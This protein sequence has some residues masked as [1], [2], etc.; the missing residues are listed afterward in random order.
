MKVGQEAESPRDEIAELRAALAREERIASALREVGNALGTTLDLDDLLELI[1]G[2]LTDLLEADRCTLYL[3]DQAK[4]ELV[5]RI[6]IGEQV[7]SIRV[8]VG[9]GIAGTV[10]KTGKAI[11]LRDAYTDPR[12]EP[13]WD[14]FTGY[15]TRSMLAAPLK[16]HMGRTIGVIQVL[17][18]TVG[19][20]FTAEDEAILSALS[21]QAAVAIDNSRLFLS[22]IQK[23]HQLLS[24]K[25]KLERRV[26]DLQLLNELE[27]AMARA[28]SLEDLTRAALSALAKACQAQGA[29]LLLGEEDTGDLFQYVYDAERP[30][31]LDRFGIKAGEGL[32][33][34]AM[35]SGETIELEDASLGPH[36]HARVEGRFPF[37]IQSCL[38]MPLS[39]E[40]VFGALGL[41]SKRGG[42]PFEEEDRSLMG[43][44]GA[45]LSTAVRLFRASVQRERG[46][47]LT[48]IGRL[49]SQV[50]H[51]FKT[52]MTVI[53]GHV[54][55]MTSAD[56]P[57]VRAEHAAGVLKQLQMLTAMQ[58]EVLDFARGERRI[59]VR[60]VYL[61]RFFDDI[62]KQVEQ[63]AEGQP[64][65]VVFDV[66]TMVTARFD[67]FRVARA[68][69]NLARNAVEAMSKAGGVLT[70][71]AHMDG[72]D[73]VIR[74]SD[75]GPGI[76]E[77]I[78]GR[79][80]QSFV[81]AGKQGGT[82]LGLAIVKKIVQEHKGSI[83]VRSSA[84]GATFELRLPQGVQIQSVL[85]E[86]GV[87]ADEP[88]V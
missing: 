57:S 86:R 27:R 58:R 15:R 8:R 43:L 73:L 76:P 19:E 21:T 45:N 54:Q 9:H 6:V 69:Q 64:I 12:F 31:A 49:L 52:P 35:S 5:S 25:E 11:R 62:K 82:G 67:E 88:S 78:Q 40:Q 4:G 80:F 53:S 48:T 36:F 22:L 14:L 32:A 26:A 10:A 20:E 39:S 23:N 56:E 17:N 59:F 61:N 63:Y 71:Y 77:E 87:L 34:H 84:E 70:I 65:K 24:T 79:M 30:D 47:R 81:T 13:E 46:Q 1:L 75:T 3:L 38:V 51:D 7:R 66:D 83:E 68:I 33:A 60:R 42:R 18:K 16:N 50:I 55:M 74:V 29:T 37:P 85:P 28:E 44:V 2:R 72:D 41:F